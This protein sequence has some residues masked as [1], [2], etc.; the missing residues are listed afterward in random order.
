MAGLVLPAA[1][2][3]SSSAAPGP[4]GRQA[5]GSGPGRSGPA[6]HVRMVLGRDRVRGRSPKAISPMFQDRI[7]AI[8]S[9]Y[10]QKHTPLPLPATQQARLP[11]PEEDERPGEDPGP[12]G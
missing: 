10:I 5:S 7:S 8:P 12:F 3:P 4:A 6:S 1:P 9:G 2:G 11:R